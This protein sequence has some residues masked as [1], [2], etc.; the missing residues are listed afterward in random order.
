MTNVI[1]G[2]DAIQAYLDEQ[3]KKFA[4]RGPKTDFFSLKDG[5]AAKF[6]FLQEI[7]KASPNYSEKN[8]LAQFAVEHQHPENFRTHAV[9]SK[10]VEGECYGCEQHQKDFKA[11]WGPKQ[12][13]YVNIAV[14][15]PDGFKVM[16]MSQ[17]VNKKANIG[18]AIL[19][20]ARELGTITDRY[21]KIK[22]TGSGRYDTTYTFTPLKEHELD[23]EGFELFDLKNN[24]LR[25]PSY[26]EQPAYYERWREFGDNKA[27]KSDEPKPT[28]ET[29]VNEVW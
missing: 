28:S 3:E 12:N 1:E 27:E 23:V 18:P 10:A 15:T 20:Q 19:E 9:C 13:L 24:V 26:D 6:V 22:R 2:L 4:D 21:F 7:D 5:D 8:G 29:V 16:V 14:D 25:S 11:G 17:S